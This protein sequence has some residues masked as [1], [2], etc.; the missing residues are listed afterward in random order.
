MIW[1]LKTQQHISFK[2]ILA[3]DVTTELLENIKMSFEAICQSIQVDKDDGEGNRVEKSQSQSASA[4]D[5]DLKFFLHVC[6]VKKLHDIYGKVNSILEILQH[7][8]WVM[9]IYLLALD[10]RETLLRLTF[11]NMNQT[12][13]QNCISINMDHVLIEIPIVIERLED[14]SK[15]MDD[16]FGW[17]EFKFCFKFATSHIVSWK[18]LKWKDCRFREN[19]ES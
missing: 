13:K 17:K 7:K 14:L 16:K 2:I 5:K 18:S 19:L 12:E 9:Q 15:N 6:E 10:L 3:L 4:V 1:D 8:Q 11:K